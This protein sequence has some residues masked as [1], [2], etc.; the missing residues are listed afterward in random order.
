M[1]MPIFIEGPILGR[2]RKFSKRL[3]IKRLILALAQI[4]SYHYAC[5]RMEKQGFRPMPELTISISNGI[6]VFIPALH[7]GFVI[8][9]KKG[10]E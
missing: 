1:F 6:Y 2:L 8:P 4:E 9:K 5:R 10:G 3:H 7:K